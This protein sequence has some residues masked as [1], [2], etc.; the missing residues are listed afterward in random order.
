MYGRDNP[1][2][3]LCELSKAKSHDWE[4]LVSICIGS[5]KTFV[6]EFLSSFTVNHSDA[7]TSQTQESHHCSSF[8]EAVTVKLVEK[9]MDC[10]DN[11]AIKYI[12]DNN[13]TYTDIYQELVDAHGAL[14]LVLDDVTDI[15]TNPVNPKHWFTSWN[16]AA[17]ADAID[18]TNI[19]SEHELM[20]MINYLITE[21]LP[22][23][24]CIVY[25][26]GRAPEHTYKIL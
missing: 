11:T 15:L 20:R 9:V 23:P 17:A 26:T 16:D 2:N 1:L 8:E 5:G 19:V 14:V 22:I 24:G 4:M 13:L 10:N 18:N 21:V 3:F 12:N 25:L 6:G 7:L